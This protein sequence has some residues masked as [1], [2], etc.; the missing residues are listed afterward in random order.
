MSSNARRA[1]QY[2]TFEVPLRVPPS[3]EVEEVLACLGLQLPDRVLAHPKAQF[4]EVD[5]IC[6]QG[7]FA[8]R[9]RLQ[10]VNGVDRLALLEASP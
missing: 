8:L 6:T 3:L 4:A 7:I 1:N 5:T 9:G 2:C 10:R